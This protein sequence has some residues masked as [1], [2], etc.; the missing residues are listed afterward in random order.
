MNKYR[1]KTPKELEAQYGPEW[2]KEPNIGIVSGMEYLLGQ[3]LTDLDCILYE[4]AEITKLG[5][6]VF[7]LCSEYIGCPSFREA[8]TIVENPEHRWFISEHVITKILLNE[9]DTNGGHT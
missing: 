9:V 5:C 2:R 3:H 6:K 7:K 4:N 8:G 1:F